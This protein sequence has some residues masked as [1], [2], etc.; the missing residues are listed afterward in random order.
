MVIMLWLIGYHVDKFTH[1]WLRRLVVVSQIY[2]SHKGKVV[3]LVHFPLG[4]G[5]ED[6]TFVD[7]AV[8]DVEHGLHAILT[9]ST[10]TSLNEL[11]AFSSSVSPGFIFLDSTFLIT[12]N[13][14]LFLT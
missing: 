13:H 9:D 12:L 10:D 1:T 6:Y 3:T 4:P 8:E 2:I 7:Q 11:D 5:Y 14:S